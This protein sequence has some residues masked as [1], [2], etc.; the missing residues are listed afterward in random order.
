MEKSIELGIGF[1]TG[2][3]NVCNIINNYFKNMLEQVKEIKRPINITLFILYDLNYKCVDRENFYKIIPE[4]YKDINIKFITPEDIEEEKKK[5][6]A[7]T[8]IKYNEI[9]LF[10]G[11]GHARGRNTFGWIRYKPLLMYI[12]DKTNYK[13]NIKDVYNKLNNCVSSMNKLFKNYD[14]NVLLE[15]LDKYSQNVEKDYEEYL[16]TNEIW[17][18]LKRKKLLG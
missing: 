15:E 6:I 7:K 8:D 2:R 1:V 17:N 14:F 11:N 13:T 3:A 16:K 4:V 9:N 10:L 12:Y 5:I 18:K